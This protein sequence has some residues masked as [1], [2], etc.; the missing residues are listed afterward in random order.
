MG[1]IA[2]EGM[3]FYAYHGYYEEE[4]KIGTDYLVYVY[5]E[6]RLRSA[7][8]TDALE[9]T[10]NYETVYLVVKMEMKKKRKL[11]ETLAVAIIQGIKYQFG[12]MQGVK[13]RIRKLRPPLGGLVSH[14]FVEESADFK[15]RCGR[16]GGNMICYSDGSCW[17]NQVSVFPKTRELISQTYNGCLCENCLGDYVR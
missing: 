12:Q 8:T 1:F 9:K 3:H 7:A 15:K 14:A 11:L 2:L 16:C 17:C 10:V 13:V 4:Q 5:I 6:Q